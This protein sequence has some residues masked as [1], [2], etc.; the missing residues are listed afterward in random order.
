MHKILLFLLSATRFATVFI[1]PTSY[2][3]TTFYIL[4]LN[5]SFILKVIVVI[6]DLNFCT[7]KWYS[8]YFLFPIR[9]VRNYL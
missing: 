9:G 5:F 6:E 4:I 2:Q 7:F 8:Q 3:E 1:V